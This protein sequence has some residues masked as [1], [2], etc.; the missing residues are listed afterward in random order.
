MFRSILFVP[1]S[2][3]ERFQKALNIGADAICV[4]LE[5]AVPISEKE[6]A[7]K[8]LKQFPSA[9][10]STATCLRINS[11]DS[12]ESKHDLAALSAID[13]SPDYLMLPK[14]DSVNELDIIKSELG[15]APRVLAIVESARGLVNVES[16]A[17][18]PAVCA[19]LFGSADY[20]VDVGSTMSWDALLYARCKI[21]AAATAA[22]KAVHDGAW[23]DIS[24][25]QGLL[26]DTARIRD[27]GFDGRVAIHPKQ[28]ASIHT[29]FA[30]T[31]QEL[32]DAEKI[33]SAFESAGG[34]AIQLDGLMIDR[35]VYDAAKAIVSR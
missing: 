24:D 27:L 18:H 16:I 6:N 11:L 33:V 23:L 20:S 2:R 8:S 14:V 1:A 34:T 3:P 25:V 22:K 21:I 28:I 10:P 9:T 19:V 7:R 17:D 5:D 4:D 12:E 30:P 31:E 13:I 32:R 29:A 35:P 26:N 15:S